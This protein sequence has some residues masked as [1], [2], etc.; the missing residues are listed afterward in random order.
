MVGS[1]GAVSA[2]SA[3]SIGAAVGALIRWQLGVRLNH[4]LPAWPP[5]TLL[6]NVLG[7]FIV[8]LA[9]AFFL[10]NPELPPEWRL[11]MVSGFCGGL[12]TF[13]TFSVEVVTLMQAGRLGTAFGLM[14]LHLAGSLLATWVGMMVVGR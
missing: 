13:S 4:L 5:G 3:V 7:G 1:I 6:A 14:G 9:I 8:G 10:K 2:V 11:L 12:T